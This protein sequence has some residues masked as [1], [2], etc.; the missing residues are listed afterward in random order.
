LIPKV[1]VGKSPIHGSGLF[2]R[3]PMAVGEMIGRFEGKETQEDGEYV[4]GI[5]GTTELRFVNHSRTP[6]AEFVDDVLVAL[7]AIQPG[8]EITCHYGESWEERNE[9]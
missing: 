9:R 3:E 4:L 7:Q 5:E 2:A 1:C 6:N 8:D